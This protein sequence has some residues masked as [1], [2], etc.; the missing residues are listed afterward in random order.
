MTVILGTVAS[1]IGVQQFRAVAD[2][3]AELLFGAGEEAGH[4]FKSDDRDVEGV[5]EAHEAGAFHR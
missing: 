4:V 1:A 2:D 5:A 3:A